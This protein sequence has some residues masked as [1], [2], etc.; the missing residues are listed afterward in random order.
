MRSLVTLAS[1]VATAAWAGAVDLSVSNRALVGKEPPT[2]F[3]HVQEDLKGVRLTLKRDDGKRFELRSRGRAGDTLSLRLTQPV[4]RQTYTGELEVHFPGGKSSSSTPVSFD[5]EVFTPLVLRIERKD[6]DLEKRTATFRLSRPAAKA[7][8]KVMLDNGKVAMDEEIAFH[9]EAAETPLTVSWREWPG[10]RPLRIWL[11][12]FDTSD[13]FES[14]EMSPWQL[15]IPHDEV[16]FE[17]GKWDII[18]SEQGKL[19]ATYQLIADALRKYG[20]FAPIKLYV[21]GHTDTQGGAESN[22][23]LSL[24]RAKSIGAYWRRKGLNVPVFYEGFGEEALLVSTKDEADE[25]KN[26]RAEYILAID[27]P[28]LTKAPFPPK[29]RGF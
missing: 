3:L 5:A 6:V 18:A 8:L 27:E 2:V 28:V 7:H 10:A 13:F 19:D 22:R 23:T 14:V 29:W 12:A 11:K 9:G 16:N 20:R 24:N 4:G 26:R 25:P 17:T 1:L 21:I 15:P